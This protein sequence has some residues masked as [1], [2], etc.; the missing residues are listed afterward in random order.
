MVD[1]TADVL[2]DGHENV[3]HSLTESHPIRE[4]QERMRSHR[5]RVGTVH[6]VVDVFHL[7]Y[8]AER[9]HF[10]P[11]MRCKSQ[12]RFIK[13]KLD[14][15]EIKFLIRPQELLN[16][17]IVHE[18]LLHSCNVIKPKLQQHEHAGVGFFE[19]EIQLFLEGVDKALKGLM[20]NILS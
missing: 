17:F 10:T 14:D 8:R 9:N 1:E 20:E 4:A 16:S 15:A 12:Q 11:I 18:E 3:L 19:G 5:K 6:H 13:K 2:D 7:S